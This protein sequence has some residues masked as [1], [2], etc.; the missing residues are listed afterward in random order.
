[1]NRAAA[2]GRGPRSEQHYTIVQRLGALNGCERGA[3]RSTRITSAELEGAR[4]HDPQLLESGGMRKSSDLEYKAQL[5]QVL[6]RRDPSELHLFLRQSAAG[7]GDERQVRDVEERSHEEMV[8]LMHRMIL[9]R[10][11]L[12]DLHAE[13][14][15]YLSG[16]PA[17]RPG[18][19]PARPDRPARRG[20]PGRWRQSGRR[21]DG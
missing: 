20:R 6:R 2:G 1:M 15:A 13:S 12:A 9:A 10:P 11:D 21:P 5:G 8:L 19:G 7:Y 4:R 18:M 17:A 14:R 3:A 16:K